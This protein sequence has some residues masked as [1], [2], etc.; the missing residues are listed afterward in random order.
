MHVCG[1][2]VLSYHDSDLIVGAFW[3]WV[4]QLAGG[5]V[6]TFAC[7]NWILRVCSSIRV[8]DFANQVICNRLV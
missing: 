3:E 1:T 2:L 6:T 7:A 4:Y 8:R 5:V